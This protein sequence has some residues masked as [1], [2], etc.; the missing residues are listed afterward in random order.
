[1]SPIEFNEINTDNESF[2][3]RCKANDRA[4][5]SGAIIST[6]SKPTATTHALYD[7][8]IVNPGASVGG[9]NKQHMNG[10]IIR[11]SRLHI[12]NNL[13]VSIDCEILA[14]ED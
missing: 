13:G 4:W 11:V 14:Q 6:M 8:D 2:N 10:R 5:L 9:F 1:V 12:A 7:K 3:C